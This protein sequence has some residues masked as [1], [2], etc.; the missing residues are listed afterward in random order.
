MKARKESTVETT[1]PLA[2]LLKAAERALSLL[3]ALGSGDLSIDRCGGQTA[4]EL[5]DAIGAMK[6]AEE[7]TR[8]S[9]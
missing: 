7:V 1:A 3:D 5:R 8:G 2:D 9:A 4:S 6:S